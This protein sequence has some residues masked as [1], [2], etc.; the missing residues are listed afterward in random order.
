MHAINVWDKTRL[1]RTAASFTGSGVGGQL[2]GVLGI[3]GSCTL[4]KPVLQENLSRVLRDSG[5]VAGPGSV[6]H[7]SS[8]YDEPDTTDSD[9]VSAGVCR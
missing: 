5:G 2:L 8:S 6:I 9:A 3:K 7:I 4:S 1:F